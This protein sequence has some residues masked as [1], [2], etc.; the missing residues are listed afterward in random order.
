MPESPSGDGAEVAVELTP[1]LDGP[2]PLTLELRVGDVLID[3]RPFVLA[4][5]PKLA[6]QSI[7][8]PGAT[9]AALGES[10]RLQGVVVNNG[11]HAAKAVKVQWLDQAA[12]LG[13]LAPGQASPF[14]LTSQVR[15]GY[16]EGVLSATADGQTRTQRRRAV[17][18]PQGDDLEQTVRGVHIRYTA[19]DPQVRWT[20]R[21]PEPETS[22]NGALAALRRRPTLP[23]LDRTAGRSGTIA[24]C[25]DSAWRVPDASGRQAG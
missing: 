9:V 3:Q 14:E 5:T 6:F 18:S 2:L 21:L 12:A 24:G 22:V 8:L 4:V 15:A 19:A 23:A 7:S 16:Q 17:L 13:E 11:R 20:A 25:R 1:L 10:V